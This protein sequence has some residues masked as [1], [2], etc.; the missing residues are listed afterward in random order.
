MAGFFDTMFGGGAEREAAE[1]NRA[2]YGDY[3]SK[4]EGFLGDAYGQSRAD[5]GGALEAWTPLADL[6]KKFGAGTDLYLDALGINGPAGNTRA[7]GAF[8]NNPGYTGAVDAGLDVMNRRRGVGGMSNSGNA[9]IDALTFGQNLQNQQY[10]SW[11]QNLQGVSQ[12]GMQSTAGAAAGQAGAYGGLAEL[13]KG[14][15]TDQTNL[16]GSTTGG[17]ANANNTEAAGQAA[18]MKN[19]LGA[20]LSLGSL[21]LSGGTGGFGSSLVG[22]F[23]PK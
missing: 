22:S 10:G 18:G 12:S 23:L 19:L 6:S 15:G 8:Q 1:K 7:S 5:M 16:L 9:D 11:L 2:L 20:G 21:A 3:Q 13:A 14:Y 4:G 17:M